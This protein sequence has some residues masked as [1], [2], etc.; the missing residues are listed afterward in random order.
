VTGPG[1]LILDPLQYAFMR[2]GLVEVLLLSVACGLVGIF[3]VQRELTFFAHALSHTIFPAVVLAAVL[4]I[5]LTAG[6]LVGA[7]V[8]IA[9]VFRLQRQREV[10][11]SGAV[12]VVLILLFALG[13]VLVGVFRV[14]SADVGASLVGDALGV[15]MSDLV[16]SAGL[17]LGLAVALRLVF[18]PLVL[19]T[20]DPSSALALG[21]PVD[22]LNL[23]LLAMVAATAIV[24]VRVVGT[25]LTV[26]VLVVPAASALRWTR[27]IR[28]AMALSAAIAAGSTLTGLY[29][30]YYAPIAPAALIV[31]VLSAVFAA[32]WALPPRLRRRPLA[33]VASV[34]LPGPSSR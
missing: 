26:A 27:R 4:R 5:D 9:L 1:G 34:S 25:I 20:F 18:W 29:I 31:L 10:G 14:R 23:L 22:R 2:N 30:A 21:L 19:T 13:V 16:L 28:P 17:T 6:A 32:S 11:H 33:R 7:I 12:G 8:S 15:G 3:V 24:S